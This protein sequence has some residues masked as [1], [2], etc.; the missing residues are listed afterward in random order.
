MPARF[1]FEWP[2]GLRVS[3]GDRSNFRAMTTRVLNFATIVHNKRKELHTHLRSS[4]YKAFTFLHFRKPKTAVG[5]LSLTLPF[6]SVWVSFR[7]F[8]RR[9]VDAP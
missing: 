6:R 8:R 1:K 7:H 5:V 2:N 4:H 3:V 9:E